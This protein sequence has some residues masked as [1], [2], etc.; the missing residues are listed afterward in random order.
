MPGRS[1]LP[2]HSTSELPGD[3]MVPPGTPLYPAEDADAPVTPS[4]LGPS[5]ALSSL[6]PDPIQNTDHTVRHQPAAE[7]PPLSA[8]PPIQPR[9]LSLPSSSSVPRVLSL[10]LHIR[11]AHTGRSLR[12]SLAPNTGEF[13][14]ALLQADRYLLHWKLSIFFF[15]LL[16]WI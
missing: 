15:V 6:R 7:E 12:F 14:R 11:S 5:S 8:S 2:E 4:D 16:S 1:L 13:S 10:P 9:D 3:N